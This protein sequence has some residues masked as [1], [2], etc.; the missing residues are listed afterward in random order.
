MKGLIDPKEYGIQGQALASK[1][2]FIK[3]QHDEAKSKMILHELLEKR[4]EDIS[5]VV[6]NIKPTDEF[7]EMLFRNLVEN[8]TISKRTRI[9]FKFKLGFER[10]VEATIK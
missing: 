6:D 7:N 10:T 4:M 2:D 3:K 5:K 9:T 1:I 8:I